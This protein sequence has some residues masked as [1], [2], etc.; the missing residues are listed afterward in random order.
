MKLNV[1]EKIANLGKI[2]DL[3][4]IGRKA[5]LDFSVNAHIHLPP[6]FSAFNTI[7]ELIC[8]AQSEGVNV[9]GCSNY[10]DYTI[11]NE[12]SAKA[13]EANIL[14]LFGTE[15]IVFIKNLADDKIRVN[16]PN[17][18][19]RMYLCGKGITDFNNLSPK[20]ERILN[21]IRANDKNR[22]QLMIDKINNIC[23]NK[24]LNIE[25]T[26][27]EI[28][29]QVAHRCK[30]PEHII[31]LQERHLAQAYQQ[32]IFE[33]FEGNARKDVLRK[34][35][36]ADIDFDNPIAVQNAL[37]SSLM[38]AGCPAYVEEEFIDFN[39][40]VEFIKELGGI[41]CYPILADG[42]IPIC[43]YEEPVDSLIENLQ[44]RNIECVEFIPLRNSLETLM[45]YV[46]KLDDANFIILAGTEHNTPKVDAIIPSCKNSQP[47]PDEIMRIFRKGAAFVAGQQYLAISEKR[48]SD[49]DREEI[50]N[51]GTGV[52][53]L[54][55]K[56]R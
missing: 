10:Y 24:N 3:I 34:L 29:S 36:S 32:V 49:L 47:I 42:V 16:D 46:K 53:K 13:S 54:F 50:I 31:Y 26:E 30:C 19:G 37:R 11:Y 22:I 45:K 7:D 9:L 43:E 27:E 51:L 56:I 52:I 55:C 23:A 8:K 40:A 38:K 35:I 6:N 2:S 12:F 44:E 39:N 1:F 15:I 18:F 5:S 20:A 25:L 33:R 41:V 21:T 17:N 48:E 28:I 14:P 4:D